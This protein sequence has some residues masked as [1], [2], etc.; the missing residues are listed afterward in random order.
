MWSTSPCARRRSATAPATSSAGSHPRR[1]QR[2]RRQPPIAAAVVTSDLMVYLTPVTFGGYSSMLKGMVDHLIQNVSPF[3]ARLDGETH[4][5]KR[6]KNNPDLLAVGWME[7]PAPIPRLCS[8][9]SSSATRSTGTPTDIL[10]MWFWQINRTRICGPRR[11]S[12]WTICRMV[13]LPR[14]WSCR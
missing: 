1:V 10:A 14:R 7:A 8:G 11:G 3:F 12:G 4:H 9:I 13:N 5:R 2:E 6:Y